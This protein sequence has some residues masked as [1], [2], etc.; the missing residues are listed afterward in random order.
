MV[1]IIM[2]TGSRA[3]FKP[4]QSRLSQACLRL[5]VYELRA[6]QPTIDI[7][8]SSSTIFHCCFGNLTPLIES[9]QRRVTGNEGR[10]IDDMHQRM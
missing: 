6:V 1:V 2:S 4:K 10:E 8:F 7:R 9:R 3:A 5:H